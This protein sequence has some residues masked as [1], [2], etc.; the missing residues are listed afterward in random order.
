MIL[1]T[2][3]NGWDGWAAGDDGVRGPRQLL[4]FWK[5]DCSKCQ[6]GWLW[7]R[8]PPAKMAS[9]KMQAVRPEGGGGSVFQQSLPLAP[10]QRAP[11][12]EENIEPVRV[13]TEAPDSSFITKERL[14]RPR[15]NF[16]PLFRKK[17]SVICPQGKPS[18]WWPGP[19]PTPLSPGLSLE[20]NVS[21]VPGERRPMGPLKVR[22][23]HCGL[24]FS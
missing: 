21:R 2:E 12:A 10:S 1:G 14:E 19:R 23:A 4:P 11:Q 13:W 16:P 3:Q 8:Q 7:R 18:S 9:S 22:A 5:L 6:L 20:A 17:L 15:W 24:T